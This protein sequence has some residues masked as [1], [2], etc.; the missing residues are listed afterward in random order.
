ME[1]EKPTDAV[2]F[3]TLAVAELLPLIHN[4]MQ[5]HLNDGT[6]TAEML[7]N[8]NILHTTHSLL[9]A[10]STALG[11]LVP[12]IKRRLK[13]FQE[14]ANELIVELRNELK[15]AK[16]DSETIIA[17]LVPFYVN[18]NKNQPNEHNMEHVV[19][20]VREAINKMKAPKLVKPTK[21]IKVG[22]GD[23]SRT[24][25]VGGATSYNIRDKKLARKHGNDD[26][27]ELF[28]LSEG[29]TIEDLTKMSLS[30]YFN[31]VIKQYQLDAPVKSQI[32]M[33][34][35]DLDK[36]KKSMKKLKELYKKTKD[37][38]EKAYV[39]RDSINLKIP[40]VELT[41]E[42]LNKTLTNVNDYIRNLREEITRMLA[43]I[44]VDK[45]NRNGTV[46]EQK[47]VK[48]P[49]MFNN[50]VIE[51]PDDDIYN[52][53]NNINVKKPKCGCPKDYLINREKA[54]EPY[55]DRAEMYYGDIAEKLGSIFDTYRTYDPDGD[56]TQLKKYARSCAS[57]L[58]SGEDIEAILFIN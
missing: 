53:P 43:Y 36:I 2:Q 15:K 30:D 34:D 55:S 57:K 7:K 38:Y 56:F 21:N 54:L 23:H 31:R 48:F 20:L 29:E 11:Y 52:I 51:L 8:F 12:R 24:Y 42:N 4:K 40:E 39:P 32:N 33:S 3:V 47:S 28:N 41:P 14:K 35:K 50:T 19:K 37:K 27:K 9:V 26:A 49:P 22:S 10:H 18:G 44:E 25:V 16:S 13:I 58:K 17:T 5:N 1:F 46:V 45:N 6:L